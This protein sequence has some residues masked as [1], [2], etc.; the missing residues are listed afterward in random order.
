MQEGIGR[1]LKVLRAER[2]LTVREAAK[3]AGVNKATISTIERG[4]HYPHALT[5]AKLARVYEVP[6]EDLLDPAP[7][8]Q[9]R[10]VCRAVEVA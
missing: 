7:A 8:R 2:G 10:R 3:R 5:L 9:P 4:E 1:R 6:L